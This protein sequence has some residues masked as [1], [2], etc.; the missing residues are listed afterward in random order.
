MDIE[1]DPHI[2]FVSFKDFDDGRQNDITAVASEHRCS[3][4]F[5][6]AFSVSRIIFHDFPCAHRFHCYSVKLCALGSQS[7]RFI[8]SIKEND[9][10]TLFKLG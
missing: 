8:S 6:F 2:L 10:Y 1:R 9:P 5:A 3:Q 4:K 7:E